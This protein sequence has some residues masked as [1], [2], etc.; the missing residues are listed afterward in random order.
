MK[1]KNVH[2]KYE[3]IALFIL[4][5]SIYTIA[6]SQNIKPHQ[7]SVKTEKDFNAHAQTTTKDNLG[8]LF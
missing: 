1:Q 4:V 2:N 6:A 8:Q 5:V 7:F 3:K